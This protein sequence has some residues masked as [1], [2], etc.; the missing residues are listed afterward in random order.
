MFVFVRTCVC[1]CVSC[2]FLFVF[3]GL[4]PLF[5]SA[6]FVF[7][8][9][10]ERRHAVGQAGGGEILGRNKRGKLSSEYSI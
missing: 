10:R 7:Y 8:R 2:A 3:L 6:L 5:Y 1:A 9:R 4:F